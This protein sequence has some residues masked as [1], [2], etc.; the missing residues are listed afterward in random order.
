MHIDNSFQAHIK[1]E[2]LTLTWDF[3]VLVGFRCLKSTFL[4]TSGNR[5]VMIMMIM[6]NQ[7]EPLDSSWTKTKYMSCVWRN[8]LTPRREN[9][10]TVSSN[11]KTGRA[12]ESRKP[13]STRWCHRKTR[14]RWSRRRWIPKWRSDSSTSKNEFLRPAVT[15]RIKWTSCPH[16]IPKRPMLEPNLPSTL[17]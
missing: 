10:T 15:K 13:Y 12:E 16:L 17:P 14:R 6:A 1:V 9:Q 2:I 7:A 3:C 11:K 5:H 8:G 4:M